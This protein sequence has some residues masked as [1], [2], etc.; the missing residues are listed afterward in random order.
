MKKR[1]WNQLKKTVM[2]TVL[3]GILGN[4]AVSAAEFDVQE[5][6]APEVQVRQ[7]AQWTD[8]KNY[9]A[10]LRLDVS[11]LKELYRKAQE[12]SSQKIQNEQEEPAADA[13]QSA[14]NTSV[15]ATEQSDDNS[16][17]N[18]S[19][20]PFG[21]ESLD[22]SAESDED[23]CSGESAEPDEDENS[24]ESVWTEE[25][26]QNTE[27]GQA[28][29]DNQ[30]KKNARYFLI[31]YISEYFQV[32]ESGLKH[33]MQAE[34]V[35]VKNQKGEDTEITKLICEVLPADMETDMFSLVI[36]VSLREEYRISPVTVSYPICQD[37]PLQ[38]N[39]DTA[40]S[41]GAY[42]LSRTEDTENVLAASQ[43]AVLNVPEA[44]TG[45]AAKLQQPSETVRAGQTVSYILE[46]KNTGEISL[47]NIEVN[48][49]FSINDVKA[50]WESEDGFAADGLKGII[51]K[52][53]P[54][55]IRKLRITAQLAETQ[56][57]KLI[58][59]VT[60]K[61]KHPGKDESI[62]CQTSAELNAA[63]LKAAFE[64]EKTADRTLAYPGDTITYQICIR[65]TGERTLHSVLSTE[66]FQNAGIQARFVQKEGVTLNSTGTQ[67]LIPQIAP[68]EAF[69][70]YATVTIPQY[71]ASQ[72][73]VNEV[74][75]IS[76]ETG[77]QT[78]KSQANV[79][80]NESE[81][82]V[83]A[84]PEPTAAA[85]QTY[86]SGYGYE[87][88]SAN[89]YAASSKPRTGDETETEVYIIFG[90]FALILAVGVLYYM[91]RKKQ[92]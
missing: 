42:F 43:S 48:S 81:N 6:T 34:S 63:E 12:D 79:T 4:C 11:G 19:A 33:D 46:V 25:N 92:N 24:G 38:K 23:E 7:N 13:G 76:D 51:T 17:T 45:I 56:S 69:A 30:L 16:R 50:E 89:A 39:Q 87:S 61:T 66:R 65:N 59:T 9:L 31:A 14:E 74:T 26:E 70:L 82:T 49:A 52:L 85:A 73:L 53:Q 80:L 1:I 86:S 68:G 57:G 47:E 40:I 21:D 2:V 75:V 29:E 77:T 27:N 55:E 90:S 10:E 58:H 22:V 83:T 91:K 5:L 72:E 18:G 20:E 37:E 62:G 15:N 67:A 8:Q 3:A 36:P 41:A 32:D 28:E 44:K 64:V 84:T 35:H 60:V 88:K 71:F 54:G 78:M